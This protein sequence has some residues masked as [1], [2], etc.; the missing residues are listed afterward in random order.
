MERFEK[1]MF[2]LTVARAGTTVIRE[3]F[4][5]ALGL[6]GKRGLK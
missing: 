4:A 6:Q 2:S 1:A 5:K 3:N